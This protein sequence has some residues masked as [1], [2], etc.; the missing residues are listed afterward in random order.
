MPKKLKIQAGPDL[1]FYGT[2]TGIVKLRKTCNGQ[3]LRPNA[4]ILNG[5]KMRFRCLWI[6]ELGEKYAGE[7]ALH[8]LDQVDRDACNAAGITW[9]ASGDVEFAR[10]GE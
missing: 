6:C 1:D 5:R 3:P 8:A 4:I 10:G 9:L 2:H 7:Y